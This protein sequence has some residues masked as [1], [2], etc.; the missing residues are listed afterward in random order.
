MSFHIGRILR[1]PTY[2]IPCIYSK[3]FHILYGG[4]YNRIK[5]THWMLGEILLIQILK[6]DVDHENK[7]E[8]RLVP[9][10]LLKKL[11]SHGF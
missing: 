8:E 6:R 7:V 5:E 4:T 10:G 9:L 3:I 2:Y 1:L 11:M